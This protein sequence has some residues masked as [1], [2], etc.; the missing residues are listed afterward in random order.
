MEIYLV[1]EDLGHGRENQHAYYSHIEDAHK[2][3]AQLRKNAVLYGETSK[4]CFRV[5][6][7]EVLDR[8]DP[9]TVEGSGF[10]PKYVH[11]E[12]EPLTNS[13]MFVGFVEAFRDIKDVT[14]TIIRIYSTY[15][16]PTRGWKINPKVTFYIP[17]VPLPFNQIVSK[18]HKA[19]DKMMQ[20][21]KQ[22]INFVKY[23]GMN[24]WELHKAGW[25][26]PPETFKRW[27]II[28]NNVNTYYK[29]DPNKPDVIDASYIYKCCPGVFE[30]DVSDI[31][32]WH[33]YAYKSLEDIIN[34]SKCV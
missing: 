26:L 10:K 3:V 27:Q 15:N 8:Y 23:Y 13:F 24:P 4:D 22:N 16:A 20:R 11:I 21:I 14:T 1:N 29:T 30:R 17:Y 7:V 28:D 5:I 34:E 33:D 6:P 12:L 19:G 2:H 18:A 9:N 31:L 32:Y 25:K